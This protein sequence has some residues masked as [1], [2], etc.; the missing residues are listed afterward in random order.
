[1]KLNT[2]ALALGCGIVWGLAILGVTLA[3]FVTGAYGE[4]FLQLMASIYPWYHVTRSISGVIVGTLSGA[5]DA[6]ICGAVIAWFYNHFGASSRDEAIPLQTV[7][8]VSK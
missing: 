8:K 6:F 4:Q 7:V 2:L 5:V 1:M 3:N